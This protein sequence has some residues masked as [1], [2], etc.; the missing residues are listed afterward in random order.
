M[1]YLYILYAEASDIYYVGHTDNYKRRLIE[2]NEISETSFTSKHRPW[3]L[4]AV[5]ECG[6]ERKTAMEIEKFIKKQKSKSL[7]KKIIKEDSLSGILAKL[8]RVPHVRD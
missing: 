1:Y 7:I 2:H 3:K 4:E 5:F 6:M 8:A